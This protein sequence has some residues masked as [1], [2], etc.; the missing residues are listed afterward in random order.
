MNIEMLLNQESISMKE[1]TIII[2]SYDFMGM[3]K[4]EHGKYIEHQIK[5]SMTYGEYIIK[6]RH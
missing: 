4:L 3:E 2:D 6:L 5:I 1:L